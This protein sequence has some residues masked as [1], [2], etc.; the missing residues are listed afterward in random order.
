M[1]VSRARVVLLFFPAMTFGVLLS[2]TSPILIRC[3]RFKGR[4]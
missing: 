1:K 2:P 3:D 4:F